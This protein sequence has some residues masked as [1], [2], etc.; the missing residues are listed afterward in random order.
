M[1][2]LDGSVS[3]IVVFSSDRISA[4]ERIEGPS[5]P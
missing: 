1:A 4:V 5:A 2:D 3:H